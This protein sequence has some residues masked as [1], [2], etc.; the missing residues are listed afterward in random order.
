[1]SNSAK[2]V[3]LP[4][5]PEFAHGF[6]HTLLNSIHG[7]VVEL[8][9]LALNAEDENE[10]IQDILF[11][12]D[13]ISDSILESGNGVEVHQRMQAINNPCY[14]TSLPFFYDKH[15]ALYRDLL[16]P[17]LGKLPQRLVSHVDGC[18]FVRYD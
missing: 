2:R 1:M 12:E 15:M 10:F 5:H 16:G 4:V 8:A 3:L 13:C 9:W 6:I 11:Y 7:S 17:Y 18:L 14:R